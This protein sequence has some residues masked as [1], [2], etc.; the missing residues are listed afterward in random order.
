MFVL[1]ID[2]YGIDIAAMYPSTIKPGNANFLQHDILK[3]SL[4]FDDESFDFIYMRQM[5]TSLTKGQ[6]I[7]FLTEITRVLKP[8]G[9]LEIVDVECQIQ[10][11][12][13]ST[14]SLIN[15]LCR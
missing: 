7:R 11:A 2:F 13:P 6:L 8:N 15:T 1:V 4:P 10:R 9:H 5:M 3:P 14:S 12:G